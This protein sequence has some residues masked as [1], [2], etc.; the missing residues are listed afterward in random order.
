MITPQLID[1]ASSTGIDFIVSKICK[2][3]VVIEVLHE[4]ANLVE[5]GARFYSTCRS[6]DG[7]KGVL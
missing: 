3:K 4:L 2:I 1:Y 6:K 7:G 5:M